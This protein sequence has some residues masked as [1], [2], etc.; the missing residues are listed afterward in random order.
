M[1]FRFRRSVRICKGVRLNLSKS[2]LSTSVGVKGFTVNAS[3]RG[4]RATASLPG[5][6]LSYSSSLSAGSRGRSY[7]SDG[8]KPQN[9]LPLFNEV[10]VSIDSNGQLQI[11]DHHGQPLEARVLRKFKQEYKHHIDNLYRTFEKETNAET[12]LIFD[13]QRRLKDIPDQQ[14]WI[15]RRE[16]RDFASSDFTLPK[17][18]NQEFEESALEKAKTEL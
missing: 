13:L 16:R 7:G 6:G 2:G 10:D 5:T 18:T 15:D 11:F 9:T 17:P 4:L 12:N 3:G 1:G 14:D 8:S